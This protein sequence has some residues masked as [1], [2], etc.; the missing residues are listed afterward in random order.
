MLP[1]DHKEVVELSSTAGNG[2]Q[3][4][5]KSKDRGLRIE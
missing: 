2:F 4:H 1:M 3:V 5:V